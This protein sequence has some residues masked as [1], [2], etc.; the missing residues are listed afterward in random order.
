MALL[1]WAYSKGSQNVSHG[2]WSTRPRELPVNKGL[3]IIGLGYDGH[4]HAM[5]LQYPNRIGYKGREFGTIIRVN[6]KQKENASIKWQFW[7]M[8]KFEEI[9]RCVQE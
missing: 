5:S 4:L 2:Q 6:G 7:S 1:G 9:I 3:E 8:P